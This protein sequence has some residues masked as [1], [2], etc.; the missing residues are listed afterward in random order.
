MQCVSEIVVDLEVLPSN[1]DFI[2]ASVAAEGQ[3]FSAVSLS[4]PRKTST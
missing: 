4:G 1:S 2:R 3:R